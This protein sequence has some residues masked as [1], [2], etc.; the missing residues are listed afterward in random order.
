MQLAHVDKTLFE[1]TYNHA[2]YLE[3]RKKMMQ[4]YSDVFAKWVPIKWNA[5]I[6]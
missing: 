2:Q 1:G 4:I 3:N 5:I 6:I